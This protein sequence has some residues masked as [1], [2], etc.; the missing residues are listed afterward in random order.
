MC[1]VC[2]EFITY[3]SETWPMRVE[4]MCRLE[5]LEKMMIRWMCGVT[6][7][8]GKASEEIRNRLGIV[9]LSGMVHQGR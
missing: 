7:R 2:Y 3:G 5:R 9:S 6:L 8:N 1:S 4:D